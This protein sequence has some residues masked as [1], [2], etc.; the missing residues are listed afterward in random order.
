[1][2]EDE[3]EDRDADKVS[4]EVVEV[5]AEGRAVAVTEVEG[6]DR[7]RLLDGLAVGVVMMVVMSFVVLSGSRALIG[8]FSGEI[9][10]VVVMVLYSTTMT[11]RGAKEKVRLPCFSLR[12]PLQ[13][14]VSQSSGK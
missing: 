3:A 12:I 13:V 1:M 14:Y 6:L 9:V 11:S 10:M 4:F 2:V 5:D 7:A 8:V